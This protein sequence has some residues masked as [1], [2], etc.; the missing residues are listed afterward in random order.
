MKANKS[1]SHA[2][3]TKET[4]IQLN[5][6]L[7]GNGRTTI[8]SGIGFFDHALEALGKHSLMNLELS[9]KG[10]THIDNH[11]SV[12]DC[13]IALGEALHKILYPLVG[14]ERFGNGSVVMDE[15]CV[16]CDMDLSNRAYLVFDTS[17]CEFRGKVGTFDV[18]LVEEFFKALCFNANISVHIVVKRG[19]NLHHIVE[20]MF[21]AFALSFRRAIS[22]NE[23]VGTPSTKGVL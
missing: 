1:I 19:K 13:G 2:R 7:Y 22:P 21:K 17:A 18:E 16:E 4:D 14:V 9:C 10:D 8:N 20:A 6:H 3:K 12:E 11:H 5:I 15:A 23:R